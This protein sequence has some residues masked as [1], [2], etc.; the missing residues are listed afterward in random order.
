MRGRRPKDPAL[1]QRR[2]AAPASAAELPAETL[3][4][5][6]TPELPPRLDG[7]RPW[8]PRTI[9]FWRDVWSSPMARRYLQAD[10]HGLF[11]T[12]DLHDEFCYRPTATLAGE[13]RR[14]LEQYGLSV[15]SRRRLDWRVR[16][17]E[18]AAPSGTTAR[19]AAAP[20][21]R[22][23]PRDTILRLVDGSRR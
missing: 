2:N 16:D 6:E 4:G 12:A 20:K 1:R 14:Q 5:D 7:Q 19:P 10:I 18:P 22:P 11:I 3:V 23:D 17:D 13:L 21:R 9:A 15:M 8:H